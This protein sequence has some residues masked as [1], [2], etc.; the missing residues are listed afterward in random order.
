MDKKLYR[1]TKEKMVAGVCGGLSEYFDID[2]AIVRVIFVVSLFAGGAGVIAYIILWL[3][4]PEEPYVL[5]STKSD[6][7]EEPSGTQESTSE[8]AFSHQDYEKQIIEKKRKRST[9]AGI[10]L[11]LAGLLFLMDN[12]VPRLDFE[13]FFPLLLIALGAWLLSNSRRKQQVL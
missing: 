8:R 10:V 4:V 13:D 11:V 6:A 7:A 5:A 3:I 1:S 12:F 2:P 9:F